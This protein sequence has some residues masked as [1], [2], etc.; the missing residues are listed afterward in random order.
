VT[1]RFRSLVETVADE[2]LRRRLLARVPTVE[3]AAANLA[4]G[5]PPTVQHDDLHDA[6]VLAGLD[7]LGPPAFF[8]WGDAMVSHPFATLLVTR[9]VL[10]MRL[11]KDAESSAADRLTDAYL[12]AWADIAPR[13]RL[14]DHVDDALVVGAVGRAWSWA[15]ALQAAP[16]PEWDRWEQPVAHWLSELP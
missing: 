2:D 9:R 7:G 16:E 13:A 12:D 4:D 10:T 14:R 3:Q 8:D 5:V 15:R 6:N 1:E 11:G